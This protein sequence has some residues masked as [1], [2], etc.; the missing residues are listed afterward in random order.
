MPPEQRYRGSMDQD[1]MGNRMLKAPKWLTPEA[2]RDWILNERIL[3]I[4]Y[5][6]NTHLEIVKRSGCILKFLAKQGAL[7]TEAVELIWK[8]QGKH[9]EMV[10]V[11]YITISE[12][13]PY[14]DSNFIN[15]F[16][17]KIQQ[18]PAS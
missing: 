1:M 6:E 7:P 15:L 14:L 4:V 3:H 11:I 5:G 10:R 2:M 18:V 13:V 17:A 12:L 16:F 8:Q 9:E